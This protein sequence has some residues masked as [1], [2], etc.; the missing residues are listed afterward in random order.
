MSLKEVGKLTLDIMRGLNHTIWGGTEGV[1]KVSKIVKGGLSIADVGIGTSHTLE[2]AACNDYVCAT[3]DAI[4]T[5]STTIGLVL[6]NIPVTK[7][8]TTVTGSITVG[9]RS[10]RWYCKNYGTFWGC[11]IAAGQGIKH[12]FN[13]P[14]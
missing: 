6:G 12:T 7:K 14:K 3:F 4:G 1:Q 5:V 11:A 9:C 13:I 10:I 2:D 8:Y